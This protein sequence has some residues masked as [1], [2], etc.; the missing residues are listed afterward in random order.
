MATQTQ[1]KLL[2]AFINL[3]SIVLF[4]SGFMHFLVG[5]SL[6]CGPLPQ[7]N[8]TDSAS[9]AIQ[10]QLAAEQSVGG[11]TALATQIAAACEDAEVPDVVTLVDFI[12]FTV[13]TVS[14]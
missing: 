10:R 1:A 7:G 9:V 5:A 3:V 13:T 14:T 8:G 11:D 12:Y 4:F 2:T 6:F